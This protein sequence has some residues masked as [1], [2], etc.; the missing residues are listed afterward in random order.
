MHTVSD[1]GVI[2]CVKEHWE[3]SSFGGTIRN[4]VSEV[5]VE[6]EVPINHQDRAINETVSV[7]IWRSEGGPDLAYIWESSA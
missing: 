3:K 7:R 1:S 6:C 4:I 2:P 5:H